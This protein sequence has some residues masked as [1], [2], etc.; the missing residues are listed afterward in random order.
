M[1]WRWPRSQPASVAQ[2]D[3]VVRI[4]RSLVEYFSDRPNLIASVAGG[5]GLVAGTD[6]AIRAAVT[7][8]AGMTDRFACQTAVSRLGWDPEKLPRSVSVL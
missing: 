1:P 8:V 4:L 7:Y 3:S 6:A 2:A 5:G